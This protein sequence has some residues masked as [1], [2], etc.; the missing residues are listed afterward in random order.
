MSLNTADLCDEF[1]D[2]LQISE[3]IFSDFRGNIDFSGP[4]HHDKDF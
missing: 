1:S 3:P 4:N 2:T